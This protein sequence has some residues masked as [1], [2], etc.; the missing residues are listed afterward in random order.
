[1]KQKKGCGEVKNGYTCVNGYLCPSCS[2]QSPL[3][4]PSLRGGVAQ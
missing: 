1:M 2:Y 4:I 3:K